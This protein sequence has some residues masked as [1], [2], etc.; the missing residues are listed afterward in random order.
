[1]TGPPSEGLL[2]D[3]SNGNDYCN[4][5]FMIGKYI[6]E[7]GQNPSNISGCGLKPFIPVGCY[8]DDKDRDL[9]NRMGAN[10]NN[11]MGWDQ[12]N[13]PEE[14]Y[15]EC[16]AKG[17]FYFAMQYGTECR[18]GDS[19]GTPAGDY[20]KIDDSRCQRPGTNPM[21]GAAYC[22]GCG[23]SKTNS[24]YA[25]TQL[26]NCLNPS[27]GWGSCTGNDDKSGVVGSVPY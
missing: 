24:V 14:C 9:P 1:M 18:C 5:Y 8:K 2:A 22:A 23:G 27:G 11:A 6:D 21:T 17:H 4:T 20:P 3:R 16:K 13:T 26:W 15:K 19:F 25:I 10:L 7:K 12:F